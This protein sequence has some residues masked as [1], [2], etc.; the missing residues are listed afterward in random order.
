MSKLYCVP[1]LFFLLISLLAG[2]V[3]DC[4]ENEV[5][6]RV[7]PIAERIEEM[8]VTLDSVVTTV[9]EY[10]TE[11]DQV[12]SV[13]AQVATLRGEM[14]QVTEAL[15][16]ISNLDDLMERAGQREMT[17]ANATQNARDVET[18][19]SDEGAVAVE[20]VERLRL[21][22]EQVPERIS[23][24]K[25]SIGALDAEFE[26][27]VWV[28]VVLGILTA[29]PFAVSIYWLLA[30]I[31]VRVSARAKWHTGGWPSHCRVDRG[32]KT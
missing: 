8:K 1:V 30:Y 13:P 16:Q 26:K 14:E 9:G 23:E 32:T 7:E 10:E 17:L 22:N 20:T 31:A 6:E 25:Q 19:L 27:V 4:V 12:S 5:E 2:C 3:G 28:L 18:R 15:S 29:L 24:V 21:E 11:L